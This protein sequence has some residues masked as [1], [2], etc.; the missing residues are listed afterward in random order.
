MRI[1][2]TTRLIV[3]F[4]VTVCA[5]VAMLFV[6]PISQDPGYHHFADQRMFWGTSNFYNVV[7]N[8][9]FVILGLMGLYFFFKQQALSF[10]SLA[11]L[12]LFVGVAGIG[13]GSAYYHANPTNATLVWDRIPMTITFMS[14]F[15]IIIARYISNRW[16]RWMLLPLLFIGVG[17]VIMWYTGELQGNGDLR[18]Y[19]LVQFYPMIIIPL[20]IFIYPSPRATRV[21]ILTVIVVYAIAKFFERNDADVFAVGE[22]ISGHSIK[23]LFAALSV[24]LILHMT[25]NQTIGTSGNG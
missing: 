25:K 19:A 17:S 22:I 15:S 6:P 12:T 21:Q 1:P 24:F 16:G 14:F 3:L 20:I 10:N 7:S 5:I 4:S 13:F 18:L 9:P 23:H 8:L 11:V 2:E